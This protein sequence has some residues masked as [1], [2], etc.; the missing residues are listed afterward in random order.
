MKN[1]KNDIKLIK[2]SIGNE[3][4]SIYLFGSTL[5][6]SI[7]NANDIDLLIKLKENS[8]FNEI[9]KRIKTLPLSK[10]IG[11]INQRR[12]EDKIKINSC[13]KEYDISLISTVGQ[14]RYFIKYNNNRLRQII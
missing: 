5:N 6:K 7:E 2:T 4:E 12:Y 9:E 8:S 10:K 14:L 3:I 13:E 1:I 11:N